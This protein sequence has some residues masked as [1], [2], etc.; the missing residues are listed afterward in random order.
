MNASIQILLLENNPQDRALIRNALENE[1]YNFIIKEAGSYADFY[2]LIHGC[3]YDLI[4]AS[5]DISGF[6][7]AGVLETI[8]STI[9]GIPVIVITE[10]GIKKVQ[11]N[12]VENK[13]LHFFIKKPAFVNNLPNTILSVLGSKQDV[14]QYKKEQE[15]LSR[16]ICYFQIMR[17][18]SRMALRSTNRDELLKE[19]C[20][21]INA[22]LD[23][24]AWVGIPDE[25]NHFFKPLVWPKDRDNHPYKQA[26]ANF[27]KLFK[28]LALFDVEINSDNYFLCNDVV[29]HARIPD[30]I[31]PE[32][33]RYIRSFITFPLL[34]NQ[35]VIGLFTLQSEKPGFL[36]EQEIKLLEEVISDISFVLN[37][38]YLKEEWIKNNRELVRAKEKAEQ[39]E[40]LK[41]AFLLNMSHEIRTPMNG[42]MGFAELLNENN[43]SPG[44]IHEYI[45]M[46][47]LSSKRMLETINNLVNISKIETG[48][49]EVNKTEVDINSLLVSISK[50]YLID[51]KRKGLKL[52]FKV[53]ALDKHFLLKTDKLLFQFIISNLL[54]NA[55]KFTSEGYIELGY[56]VHKDHLEFYV[57]DTG[58]GIHKEKFEF[59]FE[60]F[61]QGD[62]GNSR[63][64]EGS[65]LGL[66]ISKAYVE[67]LGG[68]IRVESVVGKGTTFYFTLPYKAIVDNDMEDVN[69]NA[70]LKEKNLKV[71][72]VEDDSTSAKLLTL[73]VGS[74]SE[75]VLE[76]RNGTEAVEICRRKGDIDLVLMDLQMTGINGFE[77]TIQIREFNKEVVII[78]QSAYGMPQN[79]RKALFVGCD[80][81]ITKPIQKTELLSTI[82]KHFQKRQE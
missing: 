68:K 53:N 23:S 13:N 62:E 51:T 7:G 14:E 40:H 49:I 11:E 41:N 45:D 8:H 31:I 48:E 5:L 82:N 55:I 64:F 27:W 35:K 76:A 2:K 58:V 28:S 52:H 71:L 19:T 74:F 54:A 16:Q 57:T 21:I 42:I 39:A 47:K 61:R 38:I 67:K 66:A 9:P 44:Q 78:A 33:Y 43:L 46:I 15:R 30:S 56:T 80:D 34:V 1:Q 79:K 24:F 20:K 25:N 73:L 18:I 29:T 77:T 4:L 17:Q 81:F 75:N 60:K 50:C 22:S 59:I 65:G 37:K 72:V 36:G 70:V 3:S 26:F 32:F 10:S 12:P 63:Q 69:I 6:N